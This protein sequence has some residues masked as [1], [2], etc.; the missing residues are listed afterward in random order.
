MG[1]GRQ[2]FDALA[3]LYMK[4]VLQQLGDYV[5]EGAVDLKLTMGQIHHNKVWTSACYFKCI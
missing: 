4:F 2:K 3:N 5:A 1:I